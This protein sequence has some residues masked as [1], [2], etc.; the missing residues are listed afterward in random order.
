VLNPLVQARRFDRRG[1]YVRRWVPE[2]RGVEGGAVHRPWELPEDHR[3]R[4]DY[5][6]PIVDLGH[7]LDR[8]RKARNQ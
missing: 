2:L 8:F 1:D 4:L 6:D 7:G 3:R 5:P